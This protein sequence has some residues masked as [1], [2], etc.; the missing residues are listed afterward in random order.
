[1]LKTLSWITHICP[2]IIV[3]L[4]KLTKLKSKE[5][6]YLI[7]RATQ[8]DWGSSSSAVQINQNRLENKEHREMKNLDNKSAIS[9]KSENQKNIRK[10]NLDCC[11]LC[12]PCSN[13]SPPTSYPITTSAAPS[14]TVCV[15]RKQLI[16]VV[17]AATWRRLAPSPPPT[18]YPKKKTL[19]EEDDFEV[20]VWTADMESMNC[21]KG[22]LYLARV[23]VWV[24]KMDLYTCWILRKLLNYLFAHP[25]CFIM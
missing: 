3:L 21:R 1:M 23:R 17:A 25:K 11:E 4:S 2:I 13:S 19:I 22:R 24:L 7:A 6:N 9:F 8:L 12:L 15:T 20:F 16:D 10:S 5:L 14:T 18:S